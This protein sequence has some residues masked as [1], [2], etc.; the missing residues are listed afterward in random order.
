MKKYNEIE[1]INKLKEYGYTYINGKYENQFSKLL[2]YDKD[3]YIVYVQFN[4]IENRKCGTS[5]FHANNPY[6]IENIKLYL[7]KHPE[8]KCT[9]KFGEYKNAQSKLCFECECGNLFFSTFGNVKNLVKNQC[10]DCTRNHK[11]L[12]YH[13][14]K[15]NLEEKGYFLQINEKEFTGVTTS[16]LICTDKDGYKYK[17]IYDSVMR[18]KKMETFAISNLF[19]I[20][21]I[22]VYLKKYTNDEYE[23]ISDSYRGTREPLEFRHKKCGR[24]FKNK[25]INVCRKRCLKKLGTNKTG[26]MCPFCEPTQLESTHALVLKQVWIHEHPD[27]EVEERSCINPNTNCSLPTDIVNHRL[28]I[29]I[30]VQS[31]FHDF[32]Y[33]KVKD[34]IK[35][36]YWVNRGYKFYAV[37]QRD[38]TTLEMIQLFFPEYMDIPTYI[39]FGYANKIDD[40]K[41][42]KLLNNGLKVPDVAK[43]VGCKTHQIYDAIQYGRITY[44]KNYIP[45]DRTSV[46]QLDYNLNLINEFETIS[47]AKTA[48]GCKNISGAINSDSHF[49]GGYFWIEKDSYYNKNYSIKNSRFSKFFIPVDQYD[50]NNNFIKHY[51]T[52]IDASKNYKCTN[53]EILRVMNGERK[54]VAG[55]IWKHSKAA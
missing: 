53:F 6:T 47:E 9:Y 49:S 13:S 35:K 44:P 45:A 32:E 31:W 16:N 8:C 24:I 29:A 52:I 4:K 39:D 2:C 22:N 30:E 36:E 27:T 41:I 5:P 48:T 17:V 38:Y 19:T 20:Y 51:N 42:Q 28:K 34:M 54:S 3:G 14:V 55:Y 50:K 43:Q 11:N 18:N 26:A 15:S 10:D 23:C 7:F 12:D 46:V 40:V 33:Q 37:D 21:N 25:W 1:F